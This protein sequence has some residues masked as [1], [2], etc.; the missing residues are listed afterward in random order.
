[1]LKFTGPAAPVLQV[2]TERMVIA[3]LAAIEA[4][5]IPKVAQ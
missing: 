5:S 4:A 2:G 1:M 3:Q